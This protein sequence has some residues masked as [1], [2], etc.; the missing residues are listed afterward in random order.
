MIEKTFLNLIY[1][2]WESLIHSTGFLRF[3]S[4]TTFFQVEVCN[5][6]NFCQFPETDRVNKPGSTWPPPPTCDGRALPAIPALLC[7]T[8]HRQAG[9]GPAGG[10]GQDWS[11][12]LEYEEHLEIIQVLWGDKKMLNVVPATHCVW[13][14]SSTWLYSVWHMQADQPDPVWM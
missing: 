9:G 6:C 8:A 10:K 5:T 7:S 1:H 14:S 4:Q 3:C 12:H 11:C 2:A 13:P